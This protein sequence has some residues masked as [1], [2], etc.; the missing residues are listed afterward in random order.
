MTNSRNI[1]IVIESM[2]NQ[3]PKNESDDLLHEPILD[4]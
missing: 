2:I 3:I 1:I 4:T